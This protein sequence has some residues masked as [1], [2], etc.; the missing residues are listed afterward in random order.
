[1]NT[2]EERI[3]TAFPWVRQS[4]LQ[5]KKTRREFYRGGLSRFRSFLYGFGPKPSYPS[6]G[7]SL[8]RLEYF[9][10]FV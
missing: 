9:V 8:A 1:M 10:C 6:S 4:S 5:M 7:A 2:S 3:R